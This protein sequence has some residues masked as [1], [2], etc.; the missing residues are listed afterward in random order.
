MIFPRHSGI[1]LHP[2]SLPGRFGIGDLGAEAFKFIDSLHNAGQHLWQILPLGPTGISNS[3]YNSSSVLAG[4]P[5][6]INP[7]QLV[8]RGLLQEKDIENIPPFPS[9]RVDYGAVY[10]F[11]QQ[12]IHKAFD[13]FHAAPPAAEEKEFELFCGQKS[14]WLDVYSLFMAL[15]EQYRFSPWQEWPED[16]KWKKPAALESAVKDMASQTGYF[17]FEQFLFYTQWT[18]LKQYCNK[19]E[20]SLIGDLP[21]FINLDSDSV[22]GNPDLFD[23][24]SSGYPLDVAGV[25]PDYFSSTGQFWGNPLYSWDEMERTGFSW[26]KD[27]IMGTLEMVD[28]IR[29]DHFRGFETYWAIPAG[30]KSAV[31][32]KWMPGP[33][34]KLFRAIETTNGHLPLIAEDLGMITDSVRALR[35]KLG[36][37]GMRVLQFAF[38]DSSRTNEHLPYN[39]IP[40]SVAYTGTHDN[41]TTSG[42]FHGGVQSSTMNE[43]QRKEEQERALKYTGTDGREIN[44]DFIRLVLSSVANTAIVPLQDVMGLDGTARM[45]TPATTSGNWEWRFTDSDKLDRG[46]N[47]LRE[48][49]S[50]YGRSS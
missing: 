21:I 4:N 41:D 35:D 23:L 26:W 36:F 5:L 47:R 42:W 25:P 29:L 34:E 30:S 22:W 32:G 20:V 18:A 45:N 3:P 10:T 12:I 48:M 40:H 46:W 8:S 13:K 17:K 14:S 9:E 44:W 15:K 37:P 38:G 19:K 31:Y 2:T 11:K 49:T 7:G 50:I 16:I 33:G 27:R 43:K 39:Y 1:L 6:L 24:D 28:T